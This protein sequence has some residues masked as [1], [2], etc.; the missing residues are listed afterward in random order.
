MTISRYINC[1]CFCS[2]FQ[3]LIVQSFQNTNATVSFGL[4]FMQFVNLS[5]LARYN[6]FIRRKR[7]PLKQK[8]KTFI[9][10]EAIIQ[11]TRKLIFFFSQRLANCR[12]GCRSAHKYFFQVF[13]FL[14]RRLANCRSGR[15]SPLYKCLVRN[16]S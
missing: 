13:Y 3:I 10:K 4:K 11:L 2:M 7:R 6:G 14:S 8:V 16:L 1:Q 9:E 12:S 5:G 15:C